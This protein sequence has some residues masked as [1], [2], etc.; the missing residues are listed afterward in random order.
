MATSARM[1]A[2]GC[3]VQ[4]DSLFSR[5]RAMRVLRNKLSPVAFI[6][7]AACFL[8]SCSDFGQVCR[9]TKA[10]ATADQWRAWAATVIER[11]KTNSTP[12]PRSEWPDFVRRVAKAPRY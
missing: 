8:A 3:T 6:A 7:A 1:V 12:L 2:H 4:A 11:S 5:N 9:E 10:A